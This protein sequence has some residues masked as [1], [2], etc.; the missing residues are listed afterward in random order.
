MK[1]AADIIIVGGS[2]IGSSVAY[3][4]LNDGYTGKITVFE[5][6]PI[7]EFSSTPRSAGGIR[8]LFTTA[9]N[10]QISRYSL[11]K[12][13]TFPD[14]MAINGEKS[15][16]DF[17]QRGYLFLAKN[18]NMTQLEN[19]AKLQRQYGVD[20]NLLSPEELLTIIP[21][22]NINDLQGGLYSPEDGYL[23]PYSVMQGYAKKAKQL[24]ANYQ[25]EQVETILQDENGV[26]GVKLATGETYKAPIV[27]NC[28]GPWAPALSARLNCPIPI[29]PLKRQ[30]I[31]FD[32]ANPLTHD[33]PLTVDPAGVYF[34]HEGKSLIAG[35][36]EKVKPGIDF[37]WSRDFFMEELWPVLGN[38]IDN[39]MR[40]KIVS[41]WAG[42]YS[43]NTEDQNAIIGEHPGINGYF[44]ACGFSGHGM[45]QAPAVGKGLAELI[46][47]GKYQ[48]LDLSPLRFERFIE[49]DL[50]IEGAIV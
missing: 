17:R 43:H 42:M 14:D 12:Y 2:V 46:M 5:K 4:L 33:L 8:Q 39:F 24:G 13:K 31:Q 44:M 21:E 1:K 38:R 23:D 27:I 25:Y 22:L 35:F 40:A 47:T 9:I 3:N 26:S 11:Q 15:E 34:R 16:I 41:G 48:T 29:T 36:S 10:I 45:Q 19:Q 37:R 7:Y 49:K 28:A 50:L 20:S 6:D 30:I 32:I 18:E